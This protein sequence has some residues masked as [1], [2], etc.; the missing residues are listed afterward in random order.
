MTSTKTGSEPA[1]QQRFPAHSSPRVWFLTALNS[2]I[3]IALAR[4]LLDHGDRVAAGVSPLEL[5]KDEAKDLEL[6][7]LLDDV[8]ENESWSSRFRV[9]ALDTRC[10]SCTR[11]RWTHRR[12]E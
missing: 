7:G 6:L 4:E 9:L 3:A 12:D 11:S 8:K 5:E 1:D 10:A 2:A